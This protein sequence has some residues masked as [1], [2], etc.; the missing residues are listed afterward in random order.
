MKISPLLRSRPP[1]DGRSASR[2][3]WLLRA[4]LLA[5]TFAVA[6][7]VFRDAIFGVPVEL[8]AVTRGDL[9]ATVVASGR[10][11][12]PQRV[13]ISSVI[14]ER[15]AKIPVA[16]G[17]AV[18]RGDILIVLDD[19]NER[20][21]VAQAQ[22]AVDQAAAKLRQLR[23]VGQPTAAE[24]LVQAE[25]NVRLAR[26]QYQ[27]N[28]DL[29]E[30]NFISQSALDDSKRN[31]D[32]A[33]SQLKSARLQVQSNSVNGSEYQM[34]QTALAQAQ[35]ALEM[36]RA[37]LSQ[38]VMRAGVD[39]VLIGR[40]VEPGDVAQPGKELMVLAPTGETQIVVQIDEK[41]LSQLSLGQKAI[42][43]ADAYPRERFNAELFYIN[44]GIDALRGSVEVKLRVP[45]PPPY[46]RQ[47][48]TVS[49]DIEVGRR[50][51]TLIAPSDAIHDAA[52]QP[53]VLVAAGG[54]ATKRPVTLGLK[55]I[56][57]VEIRDGVAA[58]D[59]LIL[60]AAGVAAGRRVRAVSEERRESP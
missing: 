57:H 36:A 5:V 54:R 53:Y 60:S 1:T 31:I 39:G 8:H 29:K 33:E 58:G 14:T 42:A 45:Q 38:T 3:P 37:R 10:V 6:G 25:A 35:A 19:S 21:A 32:I 20:A 12:S 48:M 27:R 47:D 18:R 9:V 23:E 52:T 51:G 50:S 55:G 26:Q 17:Q 22:A 46:L 13:S 49:V 30:K 34:A 16:E 11:V 7:Y 44:P 15:I 41:N 4:L 24:S 56:G 40:E 2:S 59:E 28:V 43:S